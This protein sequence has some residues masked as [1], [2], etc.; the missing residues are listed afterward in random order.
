LA[1]I[2]KVKLLLDTHIWIWSAVEPDR[3]KTNVARALDDEGNEL[4]LSPISIWELSVL[5]RKKRIE[6][7][8]E[9]EGWVER[10]LGAAKFR[11]APLTNDVVLE[12]SRLRFSHR[13]PAD[14]FIAASAKVF[15][16]T[17][18]TADPRLIKLKQQGLA[19]LAN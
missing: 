19:V 11:E 8:Q 16:L 1:G 14:H 9:L 2:E 7:D 17:L 5:V 12:V 15:E 6:L 4:W 3:L 10:A 18:V 13:D